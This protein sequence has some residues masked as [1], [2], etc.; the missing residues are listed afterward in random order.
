MNDNF[1]LCSMNEVAR[2]VGCS[3]AYV[4]KL[5]RAGRFPQAVQVGDKKIAFVRAEVLAWIDE[6]AARCSRAA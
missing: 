5:R 1:P 4:D 3:R 2:M 6:R